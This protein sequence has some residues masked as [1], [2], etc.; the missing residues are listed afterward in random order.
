M[1]LEHLAS[2]CPGIDLAAPFHD[3]GATEWLGGMAF[4]AMLKISTFMVRL[5]YPTRMQ[6]RGRGT[7]FDDSA[8]PL[9]HTGIM[10]KT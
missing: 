8:A 5:S 6:R 7:L 10:P 4:F 2:N 3:F 9:C 1:I